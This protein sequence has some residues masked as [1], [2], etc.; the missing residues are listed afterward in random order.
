[1]IDE[2]EREREG[3][4]EGELLHLHLAMHRRSVKAPVCR[5]ITWQR[6]TDNVA[7]WSLTP[8]WLQNI[9]ENVETEP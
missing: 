8:T 6:G 9:R 5:S 3:A 7:P 2:K 4:R 1:M